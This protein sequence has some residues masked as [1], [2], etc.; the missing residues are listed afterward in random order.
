MLKILKDIFTPLSDSSLEEKKEGFNKLYIDHAEFIRSSIYWMVRDQNIDDIVQDSFLKAWKSFD[1]F[2]NKSNFRTWL[3][4]IAM[5]TTYDYLR[6]N[7]IRVESEVETQ[8][9]Y[10]DKALKDLISQ[11]ILSLNLKHREA[12]ILFYKFEYGQKEIAEILSISEGTAKS[13]IYYAKEKFTLFL[14][15]N[16]VENE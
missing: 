15:N 6:K 8:A 10:E 2:N 5:N 7:K 1:Q 13:R 11:G 16:G 4:R 14:K 12:F 9:P 3:Y